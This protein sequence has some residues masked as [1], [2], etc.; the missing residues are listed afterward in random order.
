MTTARNKKFKYGLK[1]LE[2]NFGPLTFGKLLESHRLAEEISQSEMAKKLK[3][4]RQKLNDFEHGRRFPSLR[5]AADMT[6]ALGEHAP[7][8][9]SVV[10]EEMLREEDLNFKVTLTG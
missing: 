6:D 1:D 7:T 2:K 5:M 3:I 9:V 8:W 10:I 4:S